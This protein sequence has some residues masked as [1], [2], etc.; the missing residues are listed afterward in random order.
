MKQPALTVTV[1]PLDRAL[2][3]DALIVPVIMLK[4]KI[5]VGRVQ[6]LDPTAR[7]RLSELLFRHHGRTRVGEVDDQ[8]MPVRSAFGRIAVVSLGETRPAKSDDVRR[9]AASA[10]RWCGRHD[11]AH[12][13]V[14]LDALRGAGGADAAAAWVEGAVLASFRYLTLRSSLPKSAPT[15]VKRLTIAAPARGLRSVSATVSRARTIAE[16]VNLARSL[17]HEPPN[18]INPVTLAQRCRAIA[19]R[20]KLRCRILD[21]RQMRSKKMGAILAVGAGSETPPRIILL[22]HP[23]RRRNARPVVLVGKAVTL[24]TGGYSIKPAASIPEMKYDKCGGMAVIGALVAAARLN[25]GRRVVGVIGAA[26]NMISGR[27]Y[28]PGDIVRA[29]S[30]KTI[31]VLNTDAEGRLVLADCLHYALQAYRPAALIDLATL[32]G[33]CE[34]ALGTACAGLMSTDDTLADALLA[35]GERTGERLWRLPLW[36]VYRDQIAGTD[37]DIKNTGGRNAGAIT[38]GMFL[39]EFVGDKTPWAHLDIAGPAIADKSSPLCPAGGTG[40]GVRLLLDYLR[41]RQ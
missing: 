20:Y 32:T 19:R 36:P 6:G 34:I 23:G 35:S 39:K 10:L 13:A 7:S 4:G 28:R 5:D 31:E 16:S 14:A 3:A 21:A 40:F 15:P 27:A 29:A 41:K 25:L 11:V 18:V 37:G 33:A 2:R 17:A 22:E 30:G 24:D 38:A 9:A 12:A 26:E 8:I 1:K